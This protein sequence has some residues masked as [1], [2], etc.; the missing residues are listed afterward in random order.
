MGVLR[1]KKMG[2]KNKQLP[3]WLEKS[4]NQKAKQNKQN[5]TS[6]M[7]SKVEWR[8]VREDQLSN[9]YEHTTEADT[10]MGME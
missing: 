2:V 4:N 10:L 5:A 9:I 7:G 6:V 3:L 8:E 1:K